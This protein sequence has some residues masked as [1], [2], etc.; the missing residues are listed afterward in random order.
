MQEFTP[1]TVLLDRYQLTSVL[2]RGAMG[3]VW[4]GRDLRLERPV[5]VKTVAADLLAVP[6]SREEALRRFQREAKAA[7]RLHHPN[8]TTVFDASITDGL[9][10]RDLKTQNDMVRRDAV[11]EILDFGLVKVLSDTDPRLT[12]TG[13][14]IGDIACASPELL[15]GQDR[16]DG[17]TERT[18]LTRTTAAPDPWINARGNYPGTA[19]GPYNARTTGGAE[20]RRCPAVCPSRRSATHDG[21]PPKSVRWSMCSWWDLLLSV[22]VLG[23]QVVHTSMVFRACS[24]NWLR[25]ATAWF[26]KRLI[27]RASASGTAAWAPGPCPRVTTW[28]VVTQAESDRESSSAMRASFSGPSISS[29][30]HPRLRPRSLR[31]P[32]PLR[33]SEG[34]DTRVTAVF[35]VTVN[36]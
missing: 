24:T 27:R 35:L 16:L 31:C 29:P 23:V 33:D 2:G 28:T 14:S 11:V 26:R 12:M 15:S 4:Q 20:G 5:A 7:A 18:P 13:D 30:Q 9:V 10:H 32:S 8:A 22:A 36:R 3:H 34:R 1:G 17:R 21:S 25:F 19:R 6:R